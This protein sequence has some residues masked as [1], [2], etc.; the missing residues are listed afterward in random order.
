M[1]DLSTELRDAPLHLVQLRLDLSL[2]RILLLNRIVLGGRH[3]FLRFLNNLVTRH[4]LIRRSNRDNH[5]HVEQPD[6]HSPP[7]PSD[8]IVHRNPLH[9]TDVHLVLEYNFCLSESHRARTMTRDARVKREGQE[10]KRERYL[11]QVSIAAVCVV[12]EKAKGTATL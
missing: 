9:S 1:F 11:S 7:Q 3:R 6:S 2:K 10:P 12:G 5:E 8:M 4:R